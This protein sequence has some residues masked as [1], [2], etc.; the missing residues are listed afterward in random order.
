MVISRLLPMPPKELPVSSPASARKKRPSPSRYTTASTP[1][2]S[3]SGACAEII[4][5]IRPASAVAPNTTYGV[6]LKIHDAV[7]G[8]DHVLPKQLVEIAVGLQMSRPAANLKLRLERLNQAADQRS[9]RQQ[10]QQLHQRSEKYA[11]HWR[12]P[13]SSSRSA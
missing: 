5:I 13:N 7:L 6:A 9:D 10:Q 3:P 8:H 11:H 1:P 12:T 2:N 4:G